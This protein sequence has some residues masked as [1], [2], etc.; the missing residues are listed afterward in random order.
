MFIFLLFEFFDP[1]L[2]LGIIGTQLQSLAV[3][4]DGSSRKALALAFFP[5][6]EVFRCEFFQE[7]LPSSQR[8]LEALILL[9]QG[10]EMVE[11]HAEQAF[12][13]RLLNVVAT[14]DGKKE[15]VN[16]TSIVSLLPGAG[17]IIILLVGL[18]LS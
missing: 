5:H 18:G 8:F 1:T 7:L 3:V 2:R 12:A 17:S 15:L 10:F 9:V 6:H 4:F 13:G 11:L 14:V 16:E